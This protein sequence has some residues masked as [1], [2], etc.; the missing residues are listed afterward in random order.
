MRNN[1]ILTDGG[2]NCAGLLGQNADDADFETDGSSV[3][4]P[5]LHVAGLANEIDDVDPRVDGRRV[6]VFVVN[7][8]PALEQALQQIVFHDPNVHQGRDQV[9]RPFAFED[10]VEKLEH[11]TEEIEARGT[12]QDEADVLGDGGSDGGILPHELGPIRRGDRRKD[13]S[14]FEQRNGRRLQDA[15]TVESFDPGRSFLS[16]GS[17]CNSF[18][19]TASAGM[20][21][22]SF[23]AY[24]DGLRFHQPVP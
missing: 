22:P 20:K 6:L 2:Q 13:G 7:H 3:A 23:H 18:T 1:S 16:R 17:I 10:L 11:V 24:H 8:L 19:K 21:N 5:R 12:L 14:I 15:P 4:P 9:R